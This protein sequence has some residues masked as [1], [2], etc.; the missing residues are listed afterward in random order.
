MGKKDSMIGAGISGILGAGAKPAAAKEP[1]EE[2]FFVY[3][4]GRP[5]NDEPR[6]NDGKVFRK[7]SLDLD[8]DLYKKIRDLS[9]E[10]RSPIKDIIHRLLDLGYKMEMKRLSKENT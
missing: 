5:R 8:V 7:T 3:R 2:N 4:R 1:E 9:Q 10:E 6:P